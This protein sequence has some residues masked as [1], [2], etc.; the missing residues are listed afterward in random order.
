MLVFD[1]LLLAT[2]IGVLTA[3]VFWVRVAASH[4]M[5]II[6][7][8]D[9]TERIAERANRRAFNWA[10]TASGLTVVLAIAAYLAGRSAGAF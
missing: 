7:R 4:S 5:R 2:G 10:L 6:Y 8:L 3:A 9:G 1:L